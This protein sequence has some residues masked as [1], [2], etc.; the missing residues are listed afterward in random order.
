MSWIAFIDYYPLKVDGV[1]WNELGWNRIEPN[2]TPIIIM[3]ATER[4][5]N[6]QTITSMRIFGRKVAIASYFLPFLIRSQTN[7]ECELE[8]GCIVMCNFVT[9]LI[10]RMFLFPTLAPVWLI[11]HFFLIYRLIVAGRQA[12]S[13]LTTL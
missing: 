5:F 7:T 8:N 1:Y 13:L 6:N 11:G 12:F 2:R 3:R 10:W 9:Q 4:R